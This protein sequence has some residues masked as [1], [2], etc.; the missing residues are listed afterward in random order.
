MA[1][2]DEENEN[3]DDEREQRTLEVGWAGEIV[4]TLTSGGFGEAAQEDF[5][6]SLVRKNVANLWDYEGKN[7]NGRKEEGWWNAAEEERRTEDGRRR[8]CVS[9]ER[10]LWICSFWWTRRSARRS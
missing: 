1:E 5:R 8:E 4:A 3:G 9:T 6:A 2:E 10:S 7:E